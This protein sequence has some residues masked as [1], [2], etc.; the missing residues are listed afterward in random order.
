MVGLE[1]VPV[2]DIFVPAVIKITPPPPPP[3]IV[4]TVRVLIVAVE[5]LIVLIVK[6]SENVAAPFVLVTYTLFGGTNVL[7]RRYATALRSV[8]NPKSRDVI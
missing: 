3:L 2:V 6:V 5:T 1:A 4:L 7:L 8:V